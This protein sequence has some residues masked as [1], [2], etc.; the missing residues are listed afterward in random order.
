MAIRLAT[1]LQVDPPGA[2]SLVNSDGLAGKDAWGKRAVWCD[3]SG[4]LGGATVGIAILDHPSNPRHPTGWHARTY[5]LFAVNPFAIKSFKLSDKDDPF[6]IPRGGSATFR[7]RFLF[8]K[9]D[10]KAAGI[11]ARFRAWAS[12]GR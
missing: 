11:D 9:G 6:V 2:G 8:H 7:Y 5:G 1:S 4:P 10:A 3:A 12:D